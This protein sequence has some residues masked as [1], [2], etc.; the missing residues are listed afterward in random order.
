MHRI[1]AIA[2][3]GKTTNVLGKDNDL[4]WDIPADLER[5]RNVT[6]DHPIIMGRKTWESLPAE[7]RPLPKRTNIVVSRQTDYD[8]PG[9]ILVSS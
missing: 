1:T 2:A 6:R 8:A 9:A 7:R 3:I 5:F 4:V